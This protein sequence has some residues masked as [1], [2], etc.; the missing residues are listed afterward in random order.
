MQTWGVEEKGGVQ[1][2]VGLG[3]ARV[4][5]EG[6]AFIRRHELEKKKKVHCTKALGGGER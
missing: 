5:E 3:C 2:K 6:G 4:E 1:K